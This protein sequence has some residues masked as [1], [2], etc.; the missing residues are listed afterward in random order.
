VSLHRLVPAPEEHC[1]T[2]RKGAAGHGHD[3][4]RVTRAACRKKKEQNPGADTQAKRSNN[5]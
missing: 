3:F 2:D 5:A 4:A 1:Q